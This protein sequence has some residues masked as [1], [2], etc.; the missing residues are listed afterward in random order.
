MM[1][2]ASSNRATRLSK[3]NPKARYSRSFHPAPRP[4]TSRPPEIASTVAAIFASI[5]GAWN[6]VDATKGPSWTRDVTVARAAN[7]VQASQGPRVTPPGR[8]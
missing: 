4:S 6:D 5:A 7:D 1:V 2:K 3:G 8:S